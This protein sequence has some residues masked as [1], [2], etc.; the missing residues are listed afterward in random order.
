LEPHSASYERRFQLRSNIGVLPP[1]R[2]NPTELKHLF[3]NLLLNARDAMAAGGTI[4]IEA[5]REED[6]A[7]VCVRD[8]GT[9]IPEEQLET[10]FESF[11][12]TKGPRGTGLGLSMAR[13]TMARLGGS[14]VARNGPRKGAEFVLRFPLCTASAVAERKKP[15]QT[16]PRIQRSLRLLL[17]DDDPDCLEVT[18]EVLRAEPLEIDTANSGTE[19]LSKLDHN[20]YDLMLCDVGMPDVSGWQVAQKARVR[21]PAMPIFMV[22]GW[23]NEFISA[24]SRPGNVDGVIAKPV[25]IDELRAIIARAAATGPSSGPPEARPSEMA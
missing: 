6:F 9:G 3:L 7:V 20:G 19:A 4:S 24:E 23:A 25:E 15:E 5:A 2:A 18:R 17:V 21:H 10:I 12:T 22:T 1:V 8:E 16:I 11:F 14:I 13:S